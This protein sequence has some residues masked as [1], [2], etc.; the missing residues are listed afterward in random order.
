M[1]EDALENLPWS[2]EGARQCVAESLRPKDRAGK[3][4]IV[5]FFCFLLWGYFGAAV[6]QSIFYF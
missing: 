1:A 3:D 2:A 6:R 5:L 4:D